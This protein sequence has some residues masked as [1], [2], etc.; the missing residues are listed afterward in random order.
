MLWVQSPSSPSPPRAHMPQ[1]PTGVSSP[2]CAPPPALCFTLNPMWALN[3]QIGPCYPGNPLQYSCLEN[4]MDGGAWRA[5][6]HGVAEGWT[7]LRDFTFTFTSSCL[8]HISASCY[9]WEKRWNS[10]LLPS[11]STCSLSHLAAATPDFFLPLTLSKRL[12]ISR[13]CTSCALCPDCPFTGFF[14]ASSFLSFIPQ[15]KYFLFRRQLS[16]NI[17][18]FTY[19]IYRYIFISIHTHNF[20]NYLR[21]KCKHNSSI[22]KHFR[23]CFLKTKTFSYI[24]KC[25][26]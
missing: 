9:S 12:P 1:F 13:P 22:S 4:P 24:T 2:T 15:S 16:L 17:Y 11:H 23:V 10:C 20:L 7:R 14:L 6:V 19:I 8:K 3:M 18:V 21:V 26:Y 25:N 5:A